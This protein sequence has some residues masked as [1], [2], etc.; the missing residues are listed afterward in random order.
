M[1]LEHLFYRTLKDELKLEARKM[2]ETIPF[3]RKWDQKIQYL[4]F[5]RYDYKV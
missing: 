3:N 5:Y 2:V 4:R 1:E